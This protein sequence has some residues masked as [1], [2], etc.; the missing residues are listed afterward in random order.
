MLEKFKHNIQ[1][2]LNISEKTHFLLGVS[3]GIDS[4]SMLSLFMECGFNISVAHC[5]FKLRSKESDREEEFVRSFCLQKNIPFFSKHF[6]TQKISKETKK[7]IQETA[8]NLRYEWFQ[9]IAHEKGIEYIAVAHNKDDSIETF[10]INLLRKTGLEGL[11]GIPMINNNII[12][13]LLWAERKEIEDYVARKK[14]P[15]LTDSSNLES[16]YMRNN[17]RHHLIPLLENIRPKSKEQ[18]AGTIA[19]LNDTMSLFNEFLNKAEQDFLTVH[20]DETHIDLDKLSIYENSGQLLFHT[21]KKRGFKAGVLSDILQDKPFGCGKKIFSGNFELHK[22]RNKLIITSGDKSPVPGQKKIE[23][24]E[25]N[26]DYPVN[27]RISIENISSE[28]IINKDKSIAY[29]DEEMIKYPMKIRKWKKGDT[30]CPFGMNK[31][32]KKISDYLIDTKKSIREKEK[33]FLLINGNDDVLWIIGERSDER[34][35]ITKE[36]KKNLIVTLKNKEEQDIL[37]LR[38]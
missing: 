18:I 37:N 1:A 6:Q 9:K 17:I 10:F 8:R 21:L 30:F 25:K 11:C 35:K 26:I 20:N 3:G 22:D 29:F 27:L 24:G 4:M 2:K 33:T 38:S 36:T 34:Y 23:K 31:K 16:H 13:P 14:I 28:S 32:K 12:R 19:S 15:F 7:T 5:N